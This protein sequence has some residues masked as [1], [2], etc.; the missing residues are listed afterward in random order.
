MHIL[1]IEDDDN[2][3]LFWRES[4]ML[5]GHVVTACSDVEAATDAL[6]V[7]HFDLILADLFLREGNS[8]ALLDVTAYSSPDTQVILITGSEEFPNGELF[9][10]CK[11]ISWLLRKP[12]PM[13]DLISLISHIER[14]SRSANSPPD[15]SIRWA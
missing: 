12:V 6:R 7:Q 2:L 3:C 15:D 4:L 10:M 5:E 11:N 9:E 14:K 1:V 13:H 8:L